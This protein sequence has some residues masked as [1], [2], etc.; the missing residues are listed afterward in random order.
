[1]LVAVRSLV[2]ICSVDKDDDVYNV[3]WTNCCEVTDNI[4][5]G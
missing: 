4:D 3:V 5:G 1:M 2:S